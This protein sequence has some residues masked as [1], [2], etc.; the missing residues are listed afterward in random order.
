MP[1]LFDTLSSSLALFFYF[2][3]EALIISLI[4]LHS[5]DSYSSGFVPLFRHLVTQIHYFFFWDVR[6]KWDV[7]V[8]GSCRGQKKTPPLLDGF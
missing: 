5:R 4:R 1:R 2:E 3:A 8:S 7:P 6:K